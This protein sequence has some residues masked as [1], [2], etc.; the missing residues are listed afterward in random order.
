MPLICG[1]LYNYIGAL[2]PLAIY[3]GLFCIF[4]V[5][6]RKGS[7]EYHIPKN[8]AIK[9]FIFLIAIQIITQI[10]ALI[11]INPVQNF[12]FLGFLLTLFIWAPINSLMEQLI[13]IY[14]F[15]AFANRFNKKNQKIIFSLLGVFLTLILV[16]LIHA[17]FWG[18]FLPSFR[19]MFPFSE[20][21]FIS[22]FIITPGYILL[23]RKTQSM[24]PIALIHIIA[25]LALVL[26][27]GYSI[28]P[29]L[30]KF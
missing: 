20:I 5:K 18:K 23:Y 30:F 8:W 3:Y 28:L 17:F 15:D 19:E 9:I 11:T 22:Q 7:W 16:G 13:W 14:V 27:S 24:L 21:F 26:G 12:S 25:D 4:I 10:T 1:I 6:W 2:I 29:Y